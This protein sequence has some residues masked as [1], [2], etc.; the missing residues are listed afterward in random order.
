MSLPAALL[1][2]L[3]LAGG[4]RAQEALVLPSGRA[5]TLQEV[6]ADDTGPAGATLRFRFV[7]PWLAGLGVADVEGDMQWLCDTYA[8]AHLAGAQPAQI[9][10]SLA[11]RP[12]AFGD[13]AP[14]VAQF[15]EAYRPEGPSCVWE[16]F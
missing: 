3:L 10:I 9:V 1:A 7:A 6:I 8:L 13:P 2:G 12:V 5:L 15:F 14:Q 4:A 16:G 11:D